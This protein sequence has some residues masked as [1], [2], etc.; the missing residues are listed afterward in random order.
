[1]ISDL[2][3]VDGWLVDHFLPAINVIATIGSIATKFGRYRRSP[4]DKCVWLGILLLL[5]ETNFVQMM[6][7]DDFGDP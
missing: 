6:N 5:N 4:E 1:M 3:S 7:P 2:V